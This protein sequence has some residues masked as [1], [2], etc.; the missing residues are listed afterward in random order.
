M[1]LIDSRQRGAPTV[2]LETTLLPHGPGH[3]GSNGLPASISSGPSCWSMLL[4]HSMCLAWNVR[5]EV[6]GCQSGNW[7]QEGIP[8]IY[9]F[10]FAH[11]HASPDRPGTPNAAGC[12]SGLVVFR[13]SF[14]RSLFSSFSVMRGTSPNASSTCWSQNFVSH[15]VLSLVLLYPSRAAPGLSGGCPVGVPLQPH[16]PPVTLVHP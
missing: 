12:L 7:R 5:V 13:W 10:L 11:L 16:L 14:R 4:L 8:V 15:D 3:P 1:A 6:L 9:C 2:A